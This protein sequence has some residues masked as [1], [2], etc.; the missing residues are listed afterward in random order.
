VELAKILTQPLVIA[1]V[2]QLFAIAGCSIT[3]RRHPTAVAMRRPLAVIFAAVLALG[4]L[5]MPAVAEL[6]NSSL[7]VRCSSGR[8]PPDFIVVLTGGYREGAT[9]DLDVLSADGLQR[10]LFGVRYWK[11][12]R[13]ARL[14]MT[15]T[16]VDSRYPGRMTELMAEAAVCHGVPAAA[17][18]RETEARSTREH[19]I[20]L[21]GMPGFSPASRLVIVTSRY[22]ERRALAEFRRY[23]VSV[24]PQ[25][26]ATPR[27]ALTASARNWIPQEDAL[28]AS[29]S[30]VHEWIGILWYGLLALLHR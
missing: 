23:F 1:I 28:V 12:H 27:E 17:I 3:L 21:L 22:H 7:E 6:L 25:A 20:R 30:A 9:R 18:I 29:T 4:I 14:V 19:P 11:E 2:V 15:G 16:R 8:L 24:E 26:V 13:G 10:V 5:S